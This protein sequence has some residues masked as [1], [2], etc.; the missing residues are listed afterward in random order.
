[1]RLWTK[2]Y[3]AYVMYAITNRRHLLLTVRKIQSHF[4][5]WHGIGLHFCPAFCPMN[6][7]YILMK[8]EKPY[9]DTNID[10]FR[11]TCGHVPEPILMVVELDGSNAGASISQFQRNN[12]SQCPLPQTLTSPW[13]RVQGCKPKAPSMSAGGA[14]IEAPRG[15]GFGK[16][17]TGLVPPRK[18]SEFFAYK[19]ARRSANT[20]PDVVARRPT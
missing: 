19:R 1:M 18:C 15:V 5:L 9:V 13:A 17:S 2:L 11:R 20:F 14:K 12:L 7:W 4:L 10:R 8:W 16:G 3:I 6:E